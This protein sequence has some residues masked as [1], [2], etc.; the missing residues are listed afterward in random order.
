M[1]IET[2]I[3]VKY[4]S[5]IATV[6]CQAKSACGSCA[7][8]SACGTKALSGLV[9]E[10]FAPQLQV[11]VA[12]ALIEGDEIKL[13][14]T[15]QS[16]L[17]SVFWVYCVPLLVLIFSTLTFSQFI[18]SELLLASGIIFSTACS[19]LFIKKIIAYK[20]L[21]EL[22]PIFLGKVGKETSYD[23]NNEG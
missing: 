2:A 14:L 16:L 19:F 9:G 1:M 7:A 20:R 12:E 21:S 6:Q 17:S 23:N 5:G 18:Q 8:R 4:E 13:G 3:V 11:A 22:T 15:E 10:K